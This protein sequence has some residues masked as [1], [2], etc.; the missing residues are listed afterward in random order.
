VT[1]KVLGTLTIAII[2]YLIK[3]EMEKLVYDCDNIIV[4]R[5]CNRV[6]TFVKSTYKKLMI[7]MIDSA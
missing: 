4:L 3:R 5:N 6:L 7:R 1:V 2:N